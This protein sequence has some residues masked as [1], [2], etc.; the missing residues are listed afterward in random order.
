MVRSRTD[1]PV[2]LS[3]FLQS[4]SGCRRKVKESGKR[5]VVALPRVKK[6]F[7]DHKIF[8]DLADDVLVRN[9]AHIE[10]LCGDGTK[11]IRGDFSLNISNKVAA[12]SLLSA[13]P[14]LKRFSPSHDLNAHQIVALAESLRAD[15]MAAGKMECIIHHHLPIF[16]TEHCVFCRFL[17]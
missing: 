10:D 15:P 3:L 6:P 5:V 12:L 2:S 11:A 1:T 17:R 7:E 14:N 8:S 4:C 16:H 13:Y 9:T